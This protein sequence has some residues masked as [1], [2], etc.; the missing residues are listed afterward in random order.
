[1]MENILLM[2]VLL[3]LIGG[4]IAYVVKAKKKGVKCIG[5]P[6]GASCRKKDNSESGCRG[7]CAGS[8]GHE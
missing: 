6:A 7:T 3:F 1:M 8:V 5:C 4:A 2:V